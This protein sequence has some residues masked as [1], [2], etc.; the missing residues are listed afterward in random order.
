MRGGAER[1]G[2]RAG[3]DLIPRNTDTAVKCKL[4]IYLQSSAITGYRGRKEEMG[5]KSSD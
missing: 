5:E 2:C 1:N 3:F 4:D